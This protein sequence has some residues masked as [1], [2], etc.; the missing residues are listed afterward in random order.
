MNSPKIQFIVGL[1]VI[2]GLIAVVYLSV[3][4]GGT[5]LIRGET[6]SLSARFTNVNGLHTGSN[7]TVAGVRIGRVTQITLDTDDMVAI[8]EFRVPADVKLDD[9]TIAAI[10]S[11]GIIGEKFISLQPGGSGMYLQPGDMII[12]TSSTIDLEDLIA[13]FAFGS[14]DD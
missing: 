12:D 7:V 6:Y 11:S 3:Q 14:V 4:I 10:R 8:V 2:A 13:R 9:D 5:R 1:F